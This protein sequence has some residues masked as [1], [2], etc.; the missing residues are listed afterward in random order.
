MAEGLWPTRNAAGRARSLG[1][2]S[3]AAGQAGEP[4]SLAVRG[5]WEARPIQRLVCTFPHGLARPETRLALDLEPQLGRRSESGR[6]CGESGHLETDSR[7][8]GRDRCGGAPGMRDRN[9][10]AGLLRP[11]L[12]ARATEPWRRVRADL[13][14]FLR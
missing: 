2:R 11:T 3:R 4:S 6:T 8:V 9:A 14:A 7:R 10:G 5:Q 13:S 12:L 1:P